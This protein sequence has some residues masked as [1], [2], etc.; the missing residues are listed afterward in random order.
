MARLSIESRM[1]VITL[2]SRGYS[3][4]QI[5]KRLQEE[6]IIVS[7]QAIYS[8]V[9]KFQ[10]YRV[11]LDLPRRRRQ[12]KITT[13]MRLVIEEALTSNDEITSRGIKSLL[14]FQWPELQVSIPTIKRVRKNMGW[15]CT[16]PHYCQLLRPV[17]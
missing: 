12:Q 10:N 17:S 3:I 14:T 8:L 15:V 11:Y 1:R 13:E 2:R 7:R 9:K 6:N 4:L 16:R 5:R